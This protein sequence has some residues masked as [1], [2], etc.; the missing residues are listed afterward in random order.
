MNSTDNCC[1]IALTLVA[2]MAIYLYST[3]NIPFLSKFPLEENYWHHT[4]Q[5]SKTAFNSIIL[6]VFVFIY[7]SLKINHYLFQLSCNYF[8]VINTFLSLS[9]IFVIDKYN[10]LFCHIYLLINYYLINFFNQFYNYY[11]FFSFHI[12]LNF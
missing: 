2:T 8:F 11:L 1:F 6:G 7:C 5:N 9:N 10:R 3:N 4:K 12:S